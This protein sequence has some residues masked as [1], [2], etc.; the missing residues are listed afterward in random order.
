MNVQGNR[1]LA[2]V[3][4]KYSP[5]PSARTKARAAAQQIK[6]MLKDW[7]K[8]YFSGFEISGSYAK[9]TAITLSTDID[10]F[11]SLI[12]TRP[13]SLEEIYNSLDERL[14]DEGF[15]TRRQNVSIRIKR[16]GIDI[17]IV[18]GRRQD[19]RSS[20]HSVWVRRRDT[21]TK[22]NINRQIA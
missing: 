15:A 4:R 3:V 18:P 14:E 16:N 17:D 9:G 8:P 5:S 20:D 11:V 13:G 22:T 2:G 19:G 1:Y 7:A 6:P 12:H 21:W 10:L